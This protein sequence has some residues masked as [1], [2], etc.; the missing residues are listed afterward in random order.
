MYV[1]IYLNCNRQGKQVFSKIMDVTFYN[2]TAVL[3]ACNIS[4]NQ[5]RKPTEPAAAI[6]VSFKTT[7]PAQ[8]AFVVYARESVSFVIKRKKKQ[9][10]RK[11]KEN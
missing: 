1:C 10:K 9:N 3:P 4:L 7:A 8:Q 6:L 5:K 2:Q 11:G